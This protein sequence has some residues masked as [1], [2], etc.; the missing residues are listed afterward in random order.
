[1]LIMGK[2]VLAF[3]IFSVFGAAVQNH[4][5][6]GA[7]VEDVLTAAVQATA[8]AI[9]AA[10]P[11]IA[12]PTPAELPR[13]YWSNPATSPLQ[14]IGMPAMQP[15]GPI[16]HVSIAWHIETR[17]EVATVGIQFATRLQSEGSN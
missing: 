7:Q 11:V 4:S 3:G 5:Q 6:V 9:R 1:M 16:R 14:G 15:A 10:G 13:G 2:A 12:A 17:G 8:P